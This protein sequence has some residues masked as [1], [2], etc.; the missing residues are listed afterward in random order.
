MTQS[1][2]RGLESADRIAVRLISNLR[3]LDGVQTDRYHAVNTFM[4]HETTMMSGLRLFLK[5]FRHDAVVICSDTR[6]LLIFCALQCLLPIHECKVVGVDYILSQPIGLR[7]RLKARFKE[8]FLRK[9][10]MFILH[11]VDTSVTT[12]LVLVVSSS[13][14]RLTT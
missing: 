4:G 2:D 10:D 13:H 7:Q 3:H 14:S 9:V 11:F 1:C 6:R 12:Y 5:A 8:V